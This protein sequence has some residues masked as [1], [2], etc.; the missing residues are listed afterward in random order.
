M[1][2]TVPT[3]ATPLSSAHQ[4]T[5]AAILSHPAPHNLAWHDVLSLLNSLATVTI[6]HNGKTKVTRNGH[7]LFIHADGHKDVHDAE[8]MKHIRDF[9]NSSAP[10]ATPMSSAHDAST[11]AATSHP[12]HHLLVVIDHREAR[13]FQTELHGTA[14]TKIV[15]HHLPN[16]SP[17]EP[18]RYLHN[19]GNDSNGQRRPELKSFYEA[20]ADHIK[21]ADAI[22]L[23]GCGT[24]ASSAATQLMADLQKHH[25]KTAARIVGNISVDEKHLTE[26]QLLAKARDFYGTNAA[27]KPAAS[28]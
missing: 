3:T 22:L 10:A 28:A 14:P 2:T 24:G 18:G 4:K 15:P 21:D 1:T 9:L 25:P 27:T 13:I 17:G 5:Q 8:Q 26:D 20:V 19:V 12:T 23:F 16:T 11:T 6:E 7:T